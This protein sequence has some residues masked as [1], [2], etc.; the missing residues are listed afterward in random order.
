[1]Y[2]FGAGIIIIF[3]ANIVALKSQGNEF[4]VCTF[5][6]FSR[7]QGAYFAVLRDIDNRDFNRRFGGNQKWHNPCKYRRLWHLHF[8]VW[9]HNRI[10][11][12]LGKV[13]FRYNQFCYNFCG[14]AFGFCAAAWVC[15]GGVSRISCGFQCGAYGVPFWRWRSDFGDYCC[16]AVPNFAAGD[17]DF[18]LC[19]NG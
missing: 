5:G 6:F 15:G 16:G 8:K 2:F 7:K 11:N 3:Y 19:G 12:G 17:R 18:V 10:C 1:M 9:K 13:L 4:K 14:I